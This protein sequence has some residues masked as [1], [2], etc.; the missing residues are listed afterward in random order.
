MILVHPN[1]NTVV[2]CRVE[3]YRSP[4]T[5]A[6]ATLMHHTNLPVELPY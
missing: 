6:D 4:P 3:E 1:R 5:V 2:S